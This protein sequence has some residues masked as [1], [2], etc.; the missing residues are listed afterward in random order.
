MHISQLSVRSV[1]LIN[2]HANILDDDD[3]HAAIKQAAAYIAKMYPDGEQYIYGGQ[4][5]NRSTWWYRQNDVNDTITIDY[6]PD[7]AL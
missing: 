1:H 4:Y 5:A 2:R 7:Y 3:Y 6:D